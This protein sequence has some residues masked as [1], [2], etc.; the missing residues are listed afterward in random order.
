MYKEKDVAR[1]RIR[2]RKRR[3]TNSEERKPC[4]NKSNALKCFEQIR[5]WVELN[6]KFSK[7]GIK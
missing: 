6:V 5:K 3:A 2:E 1:G 4:Q 7:Y